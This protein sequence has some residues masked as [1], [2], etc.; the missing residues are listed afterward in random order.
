MARDSQDNQFG[1]VEGVFNF[2]AGD[3]IEVN[4]SKEKGK[5]YVSLF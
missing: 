2:G 1:K 5:T 3:I 4:L